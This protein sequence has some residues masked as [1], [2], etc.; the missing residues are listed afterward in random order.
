MNPQAGASYKLSLVAVL[1]KGLHHCGEEGV[2][3]H[4]AKHTQ[5]LVLS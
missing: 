3:A 2:G 1:Q 5:V 4:V